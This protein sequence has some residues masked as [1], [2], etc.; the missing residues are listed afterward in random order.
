MTHNGI[1][2]PRYAGLRKTSLSGESIY[3]S[4]V[5]RGGDEE[6]VALDGYIAPSQ[7]IPKLK[8]R[9]NETASS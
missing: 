6:A 5:V 2:A 9:L 4:T 3:I 8:L 7:K 1:L